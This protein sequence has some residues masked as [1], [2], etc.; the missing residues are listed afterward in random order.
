MSDDP[1]LHLLNDRS[2]NDDGR[3]VLYWMQSAQ[4]ADDNAA[5]HRALLEG[6]RLGVSVLAVFAVTDDYPEANERHFAFMLEGLQET[7]E[8]LAERGVKLI[9][10]RGNPPDVA[11]ELSQEAAA[12]VTDAGYLSLLRQWRTTLGEKSPVRVE[13]VEADVIV[14]VG[15]ASDKAEY[16][17]RTLRP[18]IN[19]Q[20]D[21]CLSV[22]PVLTASTSSLPLNITGDLDLS[23]PEGVL[24]SLDVDRSVPRSARFTGGL[25]AARQR[26]TTFLRSHLDGYADR[27]ADPADPSTSEISPWLHFGQ[28]GVAEVVQKVLD[29]DAGSDED[30]EAYVEELVV[31]RELAVNHVWFHSDY[32]TFACLP[33]WA[34]K[35]LDEHRDDPREHVYTRKQLENA[36][37]HDPYWNAAMGE[38][39][40]TGYMH[41]MMRMYWG[42]KVLEWSNTPEYAF[43]TLLYL[44]NRYFIDGRDANSYANVSW[45]FG[46]HDRGW[47]ER[48]VFGKVRFMND[49]GLERKFDIQR[50]VDWVDGL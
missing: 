8:Q 32:G 47:T 40:K 41:N 12:V 14:P 17:A 21:A 30:K 13:C 1:R 4:R 29:A 43:K 46:L 24:A 44:N 23:D 10:R 2:V 11:V 27:R 34:R 49:K 26:L 25:S 45:I 35:T 16:A 38:M 42:K 9:G 6:N 36:D 3:Y 39:V 7:R 28:I 37:T 31:R 20:R 19:R 18:K 48:D 15:L 22:T 33:E 50:Y 5:L